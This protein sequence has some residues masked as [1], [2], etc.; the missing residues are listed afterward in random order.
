[1]TI[2]DLIALDRLIQDAEAKSQRE[3]SE[4]GDNPISHEDQLRMIRLLSTL[5]IEHDVSAPSAITMIKNIING[6]PKALATLWWNF[7]VLS[8][9][10]HL[11]WIDESDIPF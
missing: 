11:N 10:V 8:Q 5:A 3:P 7:S 2:R 6:R 1:M 4:E 9:E